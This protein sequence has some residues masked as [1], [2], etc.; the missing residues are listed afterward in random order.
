MSEKK[1]KKIKDNI[2]EEVVQD[3]AELSTQN[4]SKEEEAPSTEEQLKKAQHNYLKAL[5][6]YQNLVK[7]TA[8]EKI[9][10]VKYANEQ[11]VMEFVPVYDNLKIS[12]EHIDEKDK[13]NPWVKGIEYVIKMFK[14]LLENNGI[15]EIKT[16]GENFDPHKMEAMEG[17]GEKVVK[18]VSSGYELHGR[19]IKAAKVILSSDKG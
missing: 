15:T 11:L 16:V 19:V 4:E 3:E 10:Y 1:E 12:L 6:D 5:A 2:K 17:E 14:D 9:E 18:K 8:Q 13:E 7:R